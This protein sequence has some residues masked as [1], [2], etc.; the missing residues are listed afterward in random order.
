[1]AYVPNLF[2]ERFK[3]NP[4]GVAFNTES[5]EKIGGFSSV[6]S[7]AAARAVLRHGMHTDSLKHVNQANFVGQHPLYSS[8]NDPAGFMNDPGARKELLHDTLADAF[9]AVSEHSDDA[10]A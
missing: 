2:D 6:R 9:D 8:F 1:M 7:R 3:Y 4:A 5:F 10:E